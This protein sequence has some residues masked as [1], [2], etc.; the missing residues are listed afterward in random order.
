MRIYLVGGAV[1][2]KL[3]GLPVKEKD[4]VVVGA[5]VQDM[6]KLGYRQV[7]K[8]F[9]VFLHPQTNEEY[10]LAR[11]E[12]KVGRGYTGF[13][14]DTSPEVTLEED[15]Q[16]R[17]LTINAMAETPEGELIDP[18]GGKKD[19]K[20]RILRHVSPAF[21]EDPVRILRVGR[22]AARFAEFGFK[23]A[24]RTNTLMKKMV[25]SGEVDALVAERVWKELERALAEKN[26]EQFFQVLIAC[27]ALPILFPQLVNKNG[28]ERLQDA[29]NKTSDVQIRFAVLLHDVPE[30]DIRALCER[31]RVPSDYRDLALIVSHYLN[32]Y[33]HA[34]ELS[35]QDMV[36]FLMRLD[37]FRREE[38]FKK[39][40]RACEIAS[41]HLLSDKILHFDAE[42]H[43]QPGFKILSNH[44]LSNL[45]LS[46]YQKAKA[47]NVKELMEQGFSGQKLADK[48]TEKRVELIQEVLQAR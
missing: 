7:G 8:D 36:Q 40:L 30:K 42:S 38:R 5:T 24:P 15:L 20:A 44:S 31:Y 17:D 25:Q 14:F 19:L 29:A 26:P 1:R 23:V 28:I 4:W 43:L 3:L 11:T 48:I 18:Y 12:R 6:L 39:F 2:D 13:E 32:V 33:H 35:A 22:F 10:A 46:C 27:K 41:D 21:S 9:P 47:V 45:I 37:V 16:R 34:Q